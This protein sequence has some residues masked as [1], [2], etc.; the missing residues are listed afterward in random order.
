MKNR[1]RRGDRYNNG[2]SSNSSSKNSSSCSS[3]NDS[4]NSSSS[5]TR[6]YRGREETLKPSSPYKPCMHIHPNACILCNI[7]LICFLL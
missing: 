1:T 5:Y 4:S 7:T 3:K 6:E 2:S